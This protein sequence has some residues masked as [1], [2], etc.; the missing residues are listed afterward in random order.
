MILT[1]FLIPHLHPCILT[2]GTVTCDPPGTKEASQTISSIMV[3]QTGVGLGVGVNETDRGCS[4]E[5]TGA[6]LKCAPHLQSI[7]ILALESA[8]HHYLSVLHPP[9]GP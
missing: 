8:Y 3:P 9:P 7:S 5:D 4:Q 2:S 6:S 1:P